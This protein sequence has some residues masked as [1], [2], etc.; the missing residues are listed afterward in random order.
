MTCKHSHYTYSNGYLVSSEALKAM[1]A[2]RIAWRGMVIKNC[3]ECNADIS[4]ARVVR[5]KT[6]GQ[7]MKEMG[8]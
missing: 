1:K 6:V 2:G 4:Y 7:I 5:V 3:S 8:K